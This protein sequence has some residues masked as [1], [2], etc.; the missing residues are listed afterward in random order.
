LERYK[1]AAEAGVGSD[2][3]VD[4]RRETVAEEE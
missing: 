3:E 2:D 4:A 1:A